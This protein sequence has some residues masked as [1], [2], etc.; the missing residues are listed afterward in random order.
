MLNIIKILEWFSN[1][2]SIRKLLNKV[3][4]T[5]ID[6]CDGVKEYRNLP[7]ELK[8]AR[9]RIKEYYYMVKAWPKSDRDDL[10]NVIAKSYEEVLIAWAKQRLFPV[11]LLCKL[12]FYVLKIYIIIVITFF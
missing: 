8:E 2:S 6:F 9:D 12:A 10:Q 7:S 11:L 5:S 4:Q 3:K 1:I